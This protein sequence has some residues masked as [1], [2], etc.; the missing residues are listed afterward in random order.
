M[1]KAEYDAEVNTA[2]AAADL[3]YDLK[4]KNYFLGMAAMPFLCSGVWFLPN[5]SYHII[6]S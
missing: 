6:L 1:K 3:A 2:R 4:V 5:K